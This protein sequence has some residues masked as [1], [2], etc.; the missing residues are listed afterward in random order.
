MEGILTAT[1]TVTT[2]V[3]DV[4]SLMTGNAMLV[5]FLAASMLGV[6]ISMFKRVK[7]ASR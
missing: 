1:A 7:R 4:F 6:G 5:V 3:G 2:L